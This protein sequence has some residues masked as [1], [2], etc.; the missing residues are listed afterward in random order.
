MNIAIIGVGALGR[1][2]LQSLYDLKDE[3]DIFA[4]DVN[5]DALESLGL[6]FPKAFFCKCIE[7]LPKEIEAVV[8][9]TNSDV[10]RDVF[11]LLV[12]RCTV[13]NII[14]EK[15]LF[16]KEDDYY[17][18]QKKLRDQNIRSWVNC[19]RREWDVY[20][21]FK[22]ELAPCREIY[23]SAIGGEWGLGCN[24]IHFLDL[25]EYLTDEKVDEINISRLENG[26]CES[27]RKGFYEFY[28]T[29]TG[30][31]GKCKSF[32]VTCIKDSM[33]PFG[34]EIIT[35]R[36]KYNIDEGNNLIGFNTADTDWKTVEKE[37]KQVYQSQMTG[38]VVRSIIENETC[39][40]PDFNTSMEL[41]L[42]YLSKIRKFFN[43][44]GMEGDVCP[45][46]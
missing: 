38:R 32:N 27:K 12:E 3:Y 40:L 15:V 43:M 25:I 35:D 33:V 44:N 17:F 7:E 26:I 13:N 34:I 2:H 19:S 30:K 36:G 31:A 39:N 37:F 22:T 20:K 46:T 11:E 42:K 18:V 6:D 5:V 23:F 16:Q 4:V 21:A 29:L 9:A 45:I 10:R 24:A 28:G 41:H 8:I 14:F 1:R